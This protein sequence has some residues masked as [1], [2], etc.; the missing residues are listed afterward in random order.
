MD[1]HTAGEVAS[2]P[3]CWSLARSLALA[4][5]AGLPVS[6]ERVAVVGCGTSLYM[7]QAYAALR[8]AAG[9]GE[10]DAWPASEF[11]AHR[12]YDRV[13]AFSRSGTTT[14]LLEAVSRVPAGVATCA[15]TADPMAPL[16]PAAHHALLLDF[17]DERSVVQTRFPTSLLVLLRTHLGEDTAALPAAASAVL[18][19]PLPAGATDFRQYTFLGT[20]WAAAIANEA[21][22]KIREAAQA[23][24]E[25]YPAMEY[26]HGPVS[27]ADESSLVWFFGR[28][29]SGLADEVRRTGATV[30]TTAADPL[31][32]LVRAQR[33]AIEVAVSRGLDPD[34]PRNLARS[35]VLPDPH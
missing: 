9:H 11:P 21:A 24:A 3:A 32:D 26:R 18:T 16:A 22:L 30:V 4:G 10:T 31:V 2:Q 7:A 33:L 20:G 1:H 29:P 15:V 12:G 34:H 19:E 13:L 28:P 17:A 35:I 8:E 25:A 27:V 23:W 14:E 5:P 6:G